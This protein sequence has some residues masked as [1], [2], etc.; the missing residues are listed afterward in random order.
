MLSPFKTEEEIKAYHQKYSPQYPL[1]ER[2]YRVVNLKT[3]TILKELQPKPNNS[4]S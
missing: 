3:G 2:A 1:E 4:T